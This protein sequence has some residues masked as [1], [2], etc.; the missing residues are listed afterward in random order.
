MLMFV[1]IPHIRGS[2][3]HR[4]IIEDEDAEHLPKIYLSG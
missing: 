2:T 1:Y 3:Y 4:K